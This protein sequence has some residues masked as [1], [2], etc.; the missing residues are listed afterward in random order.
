MISSDRYKLIKMSMIKSKKRRST[1]KTQIS[2]I[3]DNLYLIYK[4]CSTIA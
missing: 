4:S 2:I 3:N 1:E